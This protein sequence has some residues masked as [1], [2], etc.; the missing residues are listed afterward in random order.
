MR[1]AIQ[2]PSPLVVGTHDAPGS[3]FCAGGL[4]HDIASFRVFVPALIGFEI[5]RAELPLPQRIVNA[6]QEAAFL[7]V[8]SDFEPE[9][10]QHNSAVDDVLLDLR[11]HDQKL[12]MLLFGSKTH[13]VLDAGAVVPTAVEDDDFAGGGKMRDVALEED[14]RSFA[15]GGCRQRN[16]AEYAWA[17]P[18]GDRLDGAA[19]AG[20]V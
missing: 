7:L 17:D 14:L 18:A 1:N 2:P 4:Q 9:F 16:H 12:P 3:E 11:T 19:L 6:R 8:L 20:R 10:D 15:I 13:D 5:H